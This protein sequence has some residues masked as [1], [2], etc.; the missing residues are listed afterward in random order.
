MVIL[1]GWM[2]LMSEVPLVLLVGWVGARRTY[3]AVAST[4][5]AGESLYMLQHLLHSCRHTET[6]VTCVLHPCLAH[7]LPPSLPHSPTLTPVLTHSLTLTPLRRHDTVHPL[8]VVVTGERSS[9]E[10]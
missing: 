1:G 5:R 9:R 2:F 6:L 8:L 4:I 3:N 7:F 10:M